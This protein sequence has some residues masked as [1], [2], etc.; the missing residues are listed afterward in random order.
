MQAKL[1]ILCMAL[2]AVCLSANSQNLPDYVPSDGLVAWYPF[3]GNA[4]DESG[5]GNNGQNNGVSFVTDRF[6]TVNS[7][8]SFNGVSSY[9]NGSL[10]GL[11]NPSEITLSIWLL[12]QGDAGGQPYDLFF[13][14][15]N[16]GQHTFAYAYNHSGTNIDLHSN[17]FYN[18]YSSLDIND[19]WHH[20][21]IVSGVE[22]A[23]FYV[24]GE[25]FVNMNSANWGGGCYLGSNAFYIGGG[26]DNQYTTGLIDEVGFWD[27]AL[28]EAEIEALYTVEIP[29]SGCTDETACNFDSEATSD[30]GSCIPSGCMEAEACNYN[31]LAECEGEE[32]VY[33][34]C[35]G[36]GC[37]L[38]GTTWDADLGGCIPTDSFCPEDLDGDGVIGVEDLMQLLS[39][40]GTGCVSEEP[41]TS[42]FTCGDPM[43]YHGYD[44]ATVQIGEQCW[45]AENLRNEYYA[46]GDAIPGDLANAEWITT[47]EGAQAVYIGV[48]GPDYD[49]AMLADY[50]RLYNW[51]AVDDT[52]GLCPIG[53][54]S[55]TDEDY[56]TLEIELYMSESDANSEGYR[57]TDQGTEMKSSPTDSP[58]WNG[59][60]TSGFSGL[61]GGYRNLNGDCMFEGSSGYFWSA[62]PNE[63]YGWFRGLYFWTTEVFRNNNDKRY[64]L[65][66]RCIK[67]TE[68]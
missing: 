65:S 31:T 2:C 23:S 21:V 9:V 24:D 6:G 28:T 60:N 56:M 32:C 52:R 33:S 40:F 16:Y 64:G 35:P 42:E 18:P 10:V 26:A 43:N 46:N 12:S 45:F 19:E 8:G 63:T 13:Q 11:N 20:L 55:P 49:P 5:N 29:I 59:T 17:C 36:P 48:F 14:L 66:A 54:H 22:T 30:D 39:V 25:L 3:N 47:S 58:S 38:E 68:E 53:W 61:A 15:G 67:D 34:C 4:N 41:E 57:G 50:G 62:S 7:A 27:R 44:Y 37:C 1:L 51:Y